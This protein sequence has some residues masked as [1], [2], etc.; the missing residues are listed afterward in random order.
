MG[1][2]KKLSSRAQK[3]A[4]LPAE[5][6]EAKLEGVKKKILDPESAHVSHNS[7]ENEWYTPAEYIATAGV[8]HDTIAKVKYITYAAC[9]TIS[10]NTGSLPTGGRIGQTGGGCLNP[11][12]F[13]TGWLTRLGRVGYGEA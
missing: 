12:T 11:S 5:K 7:G 1:I 8:S 4:S 6:F 10:A 9:G 3:L 13:A 2:D